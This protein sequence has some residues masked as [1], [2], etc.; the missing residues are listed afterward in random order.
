MFRNIGEFSSEGK[1]TRLISEKL[2]LFIKISASLG[3]I[4]PH[5]ISV[6]AFGVATLV[7]EL[8]V[9]L[10]GPQRDNTRVM[11][12]VFIVEVMTFESNSR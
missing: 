10:I 6:Q 11:P 1:A 2:E 9:Y 4:A 8:F 12:V 5:D 3:C 7:T